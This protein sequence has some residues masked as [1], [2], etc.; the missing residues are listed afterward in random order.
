MVASPRNE[1]NPTT[2]EI[3]VRIIPPARAGSMFNDFSRTGNIAPVI[4]AT[5]KLITMAQAITSEIIGSSNHN[6]A[7]VATSVAQIG[8]TEG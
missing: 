5:L 6:Q 1:K 3:V 8:A 4:T 7:M 2:S